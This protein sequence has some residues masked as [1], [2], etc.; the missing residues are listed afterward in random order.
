LSAFRGAFPEAMAPNKMLISKKKQSVESMIQKALNRRSEVKSILVSQAPLAVTALG[1]VSNMTSNIGQGDDINQRNGDTILTQG[2]TLNFRFRAITTDQ[3]V[4]FILFRDNFNLGTTPGVSDVLATALYRSEY[5]PMF[6]VQQK[7]FTILL[8]SFLDSNI[9]GE[10]LKTQTK[11]LPSSGKIFYNGAAVAGASNGR[12]AI[13]L[14]VIGDA[15]TG[16]H[17]Y[18]LQIRYM[19]V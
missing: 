5:N 10:T 9:N 14:L 16:L 12:G 8:D 17:E 3:T 15:T 4:R 18:T 19:D 1:T 7:R 11:R 13:F 2:Y 6:V